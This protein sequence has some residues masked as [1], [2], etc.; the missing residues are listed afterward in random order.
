[1]ND[2]RPH[3]SGYFFCTLRLRDALAESFCQNLRLQY[4]SA[5][6]RLAE[7]PRR[8]DLLQQCRKR[9]FYRYKQQMLLEH[10][11][12]ALFRNFSLAQTLAQALRQCP[13]LRGFVI[14]P[15]HLHLLLHLSTPNAGRPDDLE[16]LQNLP[17]RNFLSTLQSG[18]EYNLRLAWKRSLETSL[19]A[20]FRQKKAA[21]IPCREPSLWHPVTFDFH[22]PD[23]ESLK[24]AVQFLL[25]S[26]IIAP[27]GE[28][29][30]DWPYLYLKSPVLRP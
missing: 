26:A 12:I 27:P 28:E 24:K 9:L 23:T 17:L 30:Q 8:N 29:R 10:G 16:A 2:T 20:A 14:L 1:M 5:T 15:N 18:T 22:L 13:E 3:T 4:Y 25:Q 7:H 19:P 21:G 11:G 6:I